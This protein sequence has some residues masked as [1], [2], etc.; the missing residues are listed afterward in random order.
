[1]RQSLQIIFILI[2]A[3]LIAFPIL[4]YMG[5]NTPLPFADWGHQIIT[6]FSGL[7]F[8]KIPT[9]IYA[10]IGGVGGLT[11][12]SAGLGYIYNKTKGALK[13]T[14]TTLTSTQTQ[15]SSLTADKTQLSTQLT[16]VQ[17]DAQTQLT[18][19]QAAA[20][21]KIDAATTQANTYKTQAETAAQKI[22]DQEVALQAKTQQN[23]ADFTQTLP[24]N[25]IAMDPSTGNMIKTVEKIVIK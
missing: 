21:T 17:T 9:T 19:T 13:Q 25:S 16:Q 15:V 18:Q 12:L 24:G 11:G 1:M 10:L 4:A 20:Q 8:D 5:I 3:V 2:I 22:H 14:Q 7:K 6:F 23:I